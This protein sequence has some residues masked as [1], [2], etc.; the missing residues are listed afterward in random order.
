[1]TQYEN[2]KRGTER[3]TTTVNDLR[4]SLLEH[5]DAIRALQLSLEEE[6][7][8]T[9]MLDEERSRLAHDN[10]II[11]ER[12][13]EIKMT[14][15]TR[16][17]ATKREANA[18]M[19]LRDDV[20]RQLQRTLGQLEEANKQTRSLQEQHQQFQNQ[21]RDEQNEHSS[22]MSNMDGHVSIIIL[23]LN[24]ILI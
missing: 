22:L 20:E 9:I 21:L 5:R 10:K 19:T 4:S 2:M 18:I 1:M 7:T 14:S 17:E 15:T 13:D 16:L 12:M 6:K 24:S 23:F 3:L 11:R 8:R